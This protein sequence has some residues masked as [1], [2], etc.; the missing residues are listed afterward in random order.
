MTVSFDSLDSRIVVP[1]F[2][3]ILIPLFEEQVISSMRKLMTEDSNNAISSFLLDDDS[4]YNLHSNC[5][6][7]PVNYVWFE[8]HYFDP[9][10]SGFSIPF[11]VDDISKS[12]KQ[13]DVT[14]ID[15]PP[16]IR[17]NSGFGFLLQR[18]E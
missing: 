11:S 13:V 2:I 1:P 15:P 10:S 18:A 7:L 5:Y 3:F 6:S 9:A 14:D 17:E 8:F 4:R 16:L 12:M